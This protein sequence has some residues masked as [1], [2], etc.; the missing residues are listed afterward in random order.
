LRGY[1]FCVGN[2]ISDG[3]SRQELSGTGSGKAPVQDR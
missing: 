2:Q 1:C 3:L